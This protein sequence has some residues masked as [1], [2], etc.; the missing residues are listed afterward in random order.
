MTME[1]P[2]QPWG[3]PTFRLLYLEKEIVSHLFKPLFF[4]FL[5]SG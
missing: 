1:L 5:Q 4:F 2:D 3:T